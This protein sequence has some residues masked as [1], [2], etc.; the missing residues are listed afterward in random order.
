[1]KRYKINKASRAQGMRWRYAG[2]TDD[3]KAI[4]EEFNKYPT[5]GDGIR[6]TDT[7]TNEVIYEQ[8]R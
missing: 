7:E 2:K 6:V 3:Y 4:V 5:T 8:I 1:M